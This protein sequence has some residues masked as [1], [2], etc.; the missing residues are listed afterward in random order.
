M[1]TFCPPTGPP[2]NAT[3]EILG[4]D[5]RLSPISLP[6]PVTKLITPSGNP[7]NLNKFAN[8]KHEAEASSEGFITMVLPAAK[9]GLFSQ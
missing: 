4:F 3:N 8:S 6:K 1:Y 5:A 9:A 2:V 7:A